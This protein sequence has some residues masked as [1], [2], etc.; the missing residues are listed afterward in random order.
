MSTAF[1]PVDIM[2]LQVAEHGADARV[3]RVTGE[4]DVVTA[5]NLADCLTAQLTAAK[6]VVVD[7]DAVRFLGSAGLSVLF[8]ANEY[9]TRQGCDLR[10]VSHSRAA[11]LALTVTGLIQCFTFADSVPDAVNNVV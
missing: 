2:G 3:V 1:L 6:V 7:L 9:A 10:L 8:E 11:N 5:P 4:I